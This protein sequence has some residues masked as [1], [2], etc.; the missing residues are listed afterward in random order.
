MYYPLIHT[1]G[2]FLFT[3]YEIICLFRYEYRIEMIYQIAVDASKNMI[4]EF[5]SDF[6]INECWGY[7]RFFRIDLLE[8]EGYLDPI[9]DTIRLK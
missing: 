5:A 1:K 6:E 9:T 3:S 4:R 2:F 7:N 8:S